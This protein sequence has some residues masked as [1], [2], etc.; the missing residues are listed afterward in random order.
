MNSSFRDETSACSPPYVS[1]DASSHK[2]TFKNLN[3]SEW[4]DSVMGEEQ[5]DETC[6]ILPLGTIAIKVYSSFEVCSSR[7]ALYKNT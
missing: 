2:R 4:L 7:D 5:Q 1:I 3:I 6:R